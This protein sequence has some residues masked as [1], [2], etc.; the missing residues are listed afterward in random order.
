LIPT[1]AKH[2]PVTNPTYPVPTTA[3]FILFVFYCF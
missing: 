2:V 3:T 1:S